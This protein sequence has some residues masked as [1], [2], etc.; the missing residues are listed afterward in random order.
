MQGVLERAQMLLEKR[1]LQ[2]ALHIQRDMPVDVQIGFHM[3]EGV[4]QEIRSR[5]WFVLVNNPELA[6]P[7]QV[8]Q[9]AFC[10]NQCGQVNP[11]MLKYEVHDIYASI[12]MDL[13]TVC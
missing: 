2:R 5:Y 6:K 1:R 4:P 12:M 7:F 8:C 11:G 9:S 10:R 3:Y 13:F